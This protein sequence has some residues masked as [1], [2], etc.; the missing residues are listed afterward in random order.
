MELENC[1]TLNN[2]Y[3]IMVPANDRISMM[4]SDR[5]AVKIEPSDEAVQ[6]YEAE[7]LDEA[8]GMMTDEFNYV[9]IEKLLFGQTTSTATTSHNEDI[10]YTECVNQDQPSSFSNIK[11]S[12]D[13]Y[14]KQFDKKSFICDLC[15]YT[16]KRLKNLKMHI[17]RIHLKKK[18]TNQC[19]ICGLFFENLSKFSRHK[20]NVHQT[21]EAKCGICGKVQK[22]FEALRRHKH[23]YH[24]ERIACSA[25]GELI[26]PRY[27]KDHIRKKHQPM[28][29]T[30]C[31]KEFRGKS[32]LQQ[33]LQYVHEKT[34]ETCMIC[35]SIFANKIKLKLHMARQHP[36]VMYHCPASN[37]NYTSARKPYVKL[38]ISHHRD[39]DEDAKEKLWQQL[40]KSKPT[41]IST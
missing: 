30:Y 20:M 39:I 13:K 31:G 15:D 36:T 14:L 19:P 11:F 28:V 8:Q 35:Q 4:S 40:K 6:I 12:C 16:G 10:I 25:C 18:Y 29:C 33:H 24:A 5:V 21:S 7:Y 2:D 41:P 34:G 32:F 23:I 27:M 26:P 22:N 3:N 37:C 9:N 17:E 38:H 1:E